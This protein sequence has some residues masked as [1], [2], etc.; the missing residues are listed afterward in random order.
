[1]GHACGSVVLF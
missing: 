1:M